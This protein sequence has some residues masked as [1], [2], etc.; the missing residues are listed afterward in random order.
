MRH[1]NTPKHQP[2]MAEDAR[3]LSIVGASAAVATLLSLA[4][5]G[6]ALA[7]GLERDVRRVEVRVVE[8]AS[9]VAPLVV[10][11][12]AS[13]EG[14][15]YGTVRARD[16]E[17]DGITYDVEFG[18]IER[19][20]KARRGAEVTLR[21]GRTFALDGSNDVDDG[22]RGILVRNATG[23]HEIDWEDFVELRRPTP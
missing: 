15:L 20:R 5:V 12:R 17:A 23:A 13:G 3:N 9:P 8:P 10:V 14:R 6:R 16:G 11:A 18:R 22:N 21:D 19:I 1:E 2:S 7:G 4:L